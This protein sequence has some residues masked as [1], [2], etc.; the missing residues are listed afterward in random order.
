MLAVRT[1]LQKTELEY[2]GGSR[3]TT[4]VGEEIRVMVTRAVPM[5]ITAIAAEV[6]NCTGLPE[7]GRET[8]FLQGIH[9]T[10]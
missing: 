2:M 5:E 6:L 1:P 4:I 3:P 10:H 8:T 9:V 7:A